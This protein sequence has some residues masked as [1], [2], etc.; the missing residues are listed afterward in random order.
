MR[1]IKKIVAIFLILVGLFFSVGGIAT[2][3]DDN[4]MAGSVIMIIIGVIILALAAL[5][6][7]SSRPKT[8]VKPEN[9][10]KI[11]KAESIQPDP[12]TPQPETPVSQPTGTQLVKET[13]TTETIVPTITSSTSA[14]QQATLPQLGNTGNDAGKLAGVL[15]IAFLLNLITLGLYNRRKRQ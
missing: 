2:M 12:E 11:E 1:A 5:I 4:G 13:A 15:S 8:A 14:K 7:K 10:A 6:W 9:P 3:G